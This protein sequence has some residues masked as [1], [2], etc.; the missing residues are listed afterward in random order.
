MEHK[1]ARILS[2]LLH[3]L[4][5]PTYLLLILYQIPQLTY[6][7]YSEHY[8]L[9]LSA[10]VLM[11]TFVLPV[12]ILLLMKLLK[13]VESL[14]LEGKNER[15]LPL[16]IVAIIYFLTFFTLFR[17]NLPGFR[18][19]SFFMLGSSLL[20]LAAMSINFFTKISLHLTAWGGFTGGLTGIA[21][22]FSLNLFFWLFLIIFLSGITA[23][24][25]LENKA[26]HPFQIYLG[27]LTGFVL[28]LLLFL[29]IGIR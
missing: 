26:H 5:V 11:I 17:T 24:A 16:L 28:M 3:P 29:L 9:I 8:R 15:L 20:I 25:R 7:L 13:V 21:F 1:T 27:Y 19:F 10:F 22:L 2:V 6:S 23:Y 14:M 12:V 18:I 4:L